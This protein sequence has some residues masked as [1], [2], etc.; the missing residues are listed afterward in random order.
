MNKHIE[1]VLNNTKFCKG[2]FKEVLKE[3]DFK[4]LIFDTESCSKFRG[5]RNDAKVYSW[6]LGCTGSDK[7]IYG[8]D[9]NHWLKTMY[10]IT[11]YHYNKKGFK[12]IKKSKKGYPR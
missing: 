10:V 12:M 7:M 1:H 8:L 2:D 5:S 3:F 4:S 11:D 6:G 9:L